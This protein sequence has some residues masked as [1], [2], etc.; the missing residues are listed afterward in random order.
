MDED[1]GRHHLLGLILIIIGSIGIGIVFGW[2]I[3]VSVA[4]IVAGIVILITDYV[5]F[6]LIKNTK[7]LMEK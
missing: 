6:V 3:G 5:R 4:F 7:I 2:I 1:N